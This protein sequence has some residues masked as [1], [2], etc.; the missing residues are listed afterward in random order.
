MNQEK[1]LKNIQ[2]RKITVMQRLD[3]VD[4]PRDPFN[5]TG[6]LRREL[7]RQVNYCRQYPAKMEVLA[8][9]LVSTLQRMEQIDRDQ[10]ARD[11]KTA[12]RIARGEAKAKLKGASEHEN[13]AAPIT[14]AG[15]EPLPG[16]TV[17]SVGEREQKAVTEK[18]V[19]PA[20]KSPVPVTKKAPA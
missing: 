18:K 1:I 15:A 4:M 14:P 17:S 13:T 11:D 8:E 3:I 19:V 20:A 12:R 6:N 7:V 16:A 5:V 2:G 10:Q 9:I